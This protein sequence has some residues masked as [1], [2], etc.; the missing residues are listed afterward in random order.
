MPAEKNSVINRS[1]SLARKLS[2]I[3]LFLAAFGT[4]LLFYYFKFIPDHKA[5]LEDRSYNYLRTLAA[6]QPCAP[7]YSTH[8][9]P[10]SNLASAGKISRTHREQISYKITYAIS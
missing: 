3:Y 10:G 5:S 1:L 2:V 4:F 8:Y 7:N 6:E 9:F